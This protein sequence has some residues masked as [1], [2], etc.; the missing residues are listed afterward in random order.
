MLN[1]WVLGQSPMGASRNGDRVVQFQAA[2]ATCGG[3]VVLCLHMPLFNG[4]S[5]FHVYCQGLNEVVVFRYNNKSFS[6]SRTSL[7]SPKSFWIVTF[8]S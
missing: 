2:I 3:N 4:L 7:T 5:G 1:I 8:S 6:I